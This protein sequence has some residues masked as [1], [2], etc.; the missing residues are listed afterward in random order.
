MGQMISPQDIDQNHSLPG[1]K[2]DGKLPSVIVTF[3]CY[4]T[5]DIVNKNKKKLIVTER[6]TH[7][8][9]VGHTSEFRI[10]F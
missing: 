1:E 5:R 4:N 8:K 10:Y 6:I 3:M 7:V 9:M 2:P